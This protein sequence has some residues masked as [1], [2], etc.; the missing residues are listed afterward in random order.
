MNKKYKILFFT[1][2]ILAL[3]ACNMPAPM[4]TPSAT[5]MP[6][7]YFYVTPSAT[8]LPF[9]KV[10]ISKSAGR[11]VVAPF[12]N[13]KGVIG[14]DMT[15]E[16]WT[17]IDLSN[18]FFYTC[19][20]QSVCAKNQQFPTVTDHQSITKR[21]LMEDQNPAIISFQIFIGNQLVAWVQVDGQMSPT[22]MDNIK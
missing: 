13:E 21:I 19:V 10:E 2:V 17:S 6:T 14:F 16:S 22:Y 12:R 8:P 15:V 4:P 5:P 18:I 9:A 7:S 11:I 1:F 3:L 20:N